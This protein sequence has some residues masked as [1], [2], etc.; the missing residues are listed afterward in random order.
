MHIPETIQNEILNSNKLTFFCGAGISRD[1]YI[2]TVNDTYNYLS[3]LLTQDSSDA[4]VLEQ[5]LCGHDI[6]FERVMQLLIENSH[7]DSFLGIY[8]LGYPNINH[9]TIAKLAKAGIV[10][11]IVTTNFDTLFEKA[12]EAES[13]IE[14][15]H[16][17]VYYSEDDFELAVKGYG[18]FIRVIKI[19]GSAGP[20][21]RHKQSIRVTLATIV[22]KMLSSK[23]QSLIRH[24]L[25]DGVQDCL[26]FLGYSFSDIFDISPHIRS[27]NAPFKTRVIVVEHACA[28]MF[29]VEDLQNK[30]EKN[31]FSSIPSLGLR[32]KMHT[33]EFIN[34]LWN[35][36]PDGQHSLSLSQ[37]NYIITNNKF[38]WQDYF[39][40][41]LAS[42][43]DSL[44]L[45]L[46]CKVFDLFNAF[47]LQMKYAGLAYS[48]AVANGTVEWQAEML[49]QVGFAYLNNKKT[50]EANNCYAKGINLINSNFSKL[51]YNKAANLLSKYYF[52]QGRFLED[53]TNDFKS[54]I[55]RYGSSYRYDCLT[56]NLDGKGKTLHQLGIVLLH[57][58]YKAEQA[59]KCNEKS[60]EIKEITGDLAGMAKSILQI[61]N[62]HFF[63]KDYPNALKNYNDALQIVNDVGEFDMQGFLYHN[64]GSV[65]DNLGNYEKADF[66]Y[67]KA[68]AFKSLQQPNIKLTST[69]NSKGELYYSLKYFNTAYNLYLKSLDI[70]RYF[71]H[72]NGMVSMFS[73]FC[74]IYVRTDYFVF[75]KLQ[76][77]KYLQEASEIIVGNDNIGKK[78]LGDYLFALAELEYY[79]NGD[80]SKAWDFFSD[81]KLIIVQ[82][83]DYLFLE[84][85]SLFETLLNGH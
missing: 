80:I 4:A 83:P 73:M 62:Y 2:P 47:D 77:E 51:D 81:A 20:T 24:F 71:Q 7:S 76:L 82:I 33:S 45:H 48:K 8:N 31:P 25:C 55:K 43:K 17:K 66:N 26:I 29:D 22:Q 64:I 70:Y 32:L 35:R 19:H 63:Y 18:K 14:G 9:I 84:E 36:I 78:V 12:L 42:G 44:G 41:W 46:A 53:Y 16:F 52:Q 37:S 11:N 10:E 74:R 65:Y 68:I 61:G 79:I 23:R 50:A 67:N 54:V 40:H 59:R 38:N 39:I 30:T 34:Y 60:K 5:L 15:V 72:A 28:G 49:L 3:K 75:E 85:F 6:P 1:S 58:S 21:N 69:L 57:N 27:I 13:L 56:G